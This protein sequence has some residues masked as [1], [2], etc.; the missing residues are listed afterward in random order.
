MP[1]PQRS[2]LEGAV[3]PGKRAAIISSCCWPW[4]G[5]PGL[6]QINLCPTDKGGAKENP[7]GVRER[8]PFQYV[9]SGGR[10]Q[11]YEVRYHGVIPILTRRYR[12]TTSEQYRSS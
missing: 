6:T 3:A 12:E 9:E 7:L 4:P 10:V 8:I 5:I 11:H 2:L 1:D